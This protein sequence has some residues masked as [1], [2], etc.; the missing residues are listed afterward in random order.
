VKKE[1][2]V[3]A[4]APN[5]TNTK[6]KP[7]TNCNDPINLVLVSF[8]LRENTDIKPG[9]NGNTHGEKKERMPKK[10]A[11]NI[12]NSISLIYTTNIF[13]KIYYL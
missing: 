3:D 4:N 8:L 5:E 7:I 10:K 6:E 1:P 2:S 9:T 13:I 11:I 12:F